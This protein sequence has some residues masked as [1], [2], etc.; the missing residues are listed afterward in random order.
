[1]TRHKYK[2]DKAFSKILCSSKH[3]QSDPTQK[4]ID[5]ISEEAKDYKFEWEYCDSK[6]DSYNMFMD[7]IKETI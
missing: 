5:Q 3:S 1:M 6:Y 2:Y 7:R 4:E